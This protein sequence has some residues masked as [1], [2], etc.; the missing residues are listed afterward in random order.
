MHVA[1]AGILLENTVKFEFG[2]DPMIFDRAITLEFK[3]E[4]KKS[5][6]FRSLSLVRMHV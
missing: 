1:C 3:K 4:R 6:S 5:Y 2:H